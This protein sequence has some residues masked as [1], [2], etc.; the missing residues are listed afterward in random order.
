MNYNFD[1]ISD[2]S[3]SLKFE[4]VTELSGSRKEW[5][6]LIESL[7]T[8]K[9]FAAKRCAVR[10]VDPMAFDPLTNRAVCWLWCPRNAAG[11]R[12]RASLTLP[13][14][15]TLFADLE[16]QIKQSE[17]RPQPLAEPNF[18]NLRSQV[19][20]YIDLVDV[21]SEENCDDRRDDFQEYIFEAAIEALYG[22][23]VW[24]WINSKI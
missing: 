9:S 23:E 1:R 18:D 6:E 19:E 16:K 11:E 24:N 20:A 3:F 15:K 12:D 4:G 7:K 22:A 2:D 21:D 13:E 17:D 10:F 8:T 14:V 5:E